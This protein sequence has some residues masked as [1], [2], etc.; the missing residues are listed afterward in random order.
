MEGAA[1]LTPCPSP[2]GRGEKE[3]LAANSAKGSFCPCAPS[4]SE[5]RRLGGRLAAEA[6]APV[7]FRRSVRQCSA[8]NDIDFRL[9]RLAG[10]S[11]KCPG[12]LGDRFVGEQGS[13]EHGA[14]KAQAETRRWENGE[15]RAGAKRPHPDHGYMVPA[16]SRVRARGGCWPFGREN[17]ERPSDFR[18]VFS[19]ARTQR[20]P[21]KMGARPGCGRACL[22]EIRNA[23]P[24]QNAGQNVLIGWRI[25]PRMAE[26]GGRMR[27]EG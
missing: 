10:I 6:D 25:A 23:E 11:S 26:K 18:K 5:Y 22:P 7:P 20:I 14:G 15:F 27:D 9:T 21:R 12:A 8:G 16:L 4:I 1:A 17:A 13:G 3:E 2:E 19:A 24:Y